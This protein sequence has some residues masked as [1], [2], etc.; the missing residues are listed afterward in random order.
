MTNQA[1]A[2]ATYSATNTNT[3]KAA[4]ATE[5]SRI[6][7]VKSKVVRRGSRPGSRMSPA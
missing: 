3:E 2:R 1:I 7:P 6:L 4:R 5:Q